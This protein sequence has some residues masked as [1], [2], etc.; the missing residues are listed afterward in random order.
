MKLRLPSPANIA[1]AFGSLALF[2]AGAEI[3]LRVWNPPYFRDRNYAYH[4]DLGWTNTP[5]RRTDS[6]L[7]G[8]AFTIEFNRLGLRDQEY[9]IQKP[10]GTKRIAVLGDSFVEALQVGLEDTFWKKTAA[11]LAATQKDSRWEAI[12]FGV[13]NYGPVQEWMMLEKHALDFRP[14]AILLQIFPFN[15]IVNSIPELASIGGPEEYLRP[16]LEPGAAAGS[17]VVRYLNNPHTY[18]QRHSYAYRF[19]ALLLFPPLHGTA[20]RT[21]IAD[22]TEALAIEYGMIGDA[23]TNWPAQYLRMNVFADPAQQFPF[24]KRGWAATDE[25]I[26]RI[27]EHAKALGIPL[28][29]AVIPSESELLRKANNFS[30]MFGYTEQYEYAEQRIRALL[31]PYPQAAVPALSAP[32]MAKRAELIPYIDGHLNKAG[33]EIVAEEVTKELEKMLK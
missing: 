8:R 32:F 7:D 9:P 2:A 29:V 3:A 24:I 19:G 27:A 30:Q 4:P 22:R 31:A 33:H 16:Y 28:V 10:A 12:G 21:Q 26:R 13:G 14:D 6:Q 5:G 18:L 23:A 25:A 20:L 1:L 11:K 17:W 15:D